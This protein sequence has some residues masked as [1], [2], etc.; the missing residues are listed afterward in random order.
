[1]VIADLVGGIKNEMGC[2]GGE[3]WERMRKRGPELVGGVGWGERGAPPCYL[4]SIM[5]Y[6]EAWHYFHRVFRLVIKQ[7]CFVLRLM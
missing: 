3:G 6:I 2:V 4:K 7:L 1:M 5:L